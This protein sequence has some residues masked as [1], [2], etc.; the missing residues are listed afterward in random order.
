MKKRGFTLIEL[1]IVI[2]IIGILAAIAIPNL[3]T[4][5]CR[6]RS[7]EAQNFVNMVFKGAQGY[8][9]NEDLQ[10]MAFCNGAR[11]MQSY[12]GLGGDWRCIG[13]IVADIKPGRRY[14]WEFSADST[15]SVGGA[16]TLANPIWSDIVNAATACDSPAAAVADGVN[17]FNSAA[18]GNIDGDPNLDNLYWLFDKAA[19]ANC[20]ATA[21]SGATVQYTNAANNCEAPPAGSDCLD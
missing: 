4:W 14:Q 1:M 10:R 9:E 20:V 2:A 3:M 8:Q 17:Q 11:A 21:Q 12:M 13:V 5:V 19:P 6:S 7:T 15:N 16:A 18:C